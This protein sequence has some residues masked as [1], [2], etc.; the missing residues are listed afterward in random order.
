[1]ILAALVSGLIYPLFGHWAW[2]GISQLYQANASE[3]WLEQLGFVDFAGSTVVHSVGAWVGLA[4]ILVV[5]ARRGR[6]SPDGLPH[7]N[8]R[9]QYA[10]FQY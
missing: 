9:I 7:K 10:V 5:G 6:F 4:T 8:P 2:N 3:G 1:M